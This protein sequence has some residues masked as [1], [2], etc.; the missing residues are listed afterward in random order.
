MK[1]NEYY[2]NYMELAKLK[3]KSDYYCIEQLNY[4]KNLFDNNVPIIYNQ[5]HF[6]ELV[7]YELEYLLSVSNKPSKF[8]RTFK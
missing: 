2:D 6:S 8:Y 1:W 7:G 5:Y 3:G 4:A